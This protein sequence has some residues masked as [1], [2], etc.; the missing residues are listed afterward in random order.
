[1]GATNQVTISRKSLQK[2]LDDNAHLNRQIKDLK[3]HCTLKEEQLRAYRRLEL[4]REQLAT[5]QADLEETTKRVL[6][7]KQLPHKIP[8]PRQFANGV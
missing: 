5:L 6:K 7:V 3:R 4:P 2:I 8:L 1:M